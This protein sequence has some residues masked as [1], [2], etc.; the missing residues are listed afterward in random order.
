LK[1]KGIITILGILFFVIAGSGFGYGINVE[2]MNRQYFNSAYGFD[3]ATGTH[4]IPSTARF[5]TGSIGNAGVEKMNQEYFESRYGFEIDPN[6]FSTFGAGTDWSHFGASII[7]A[8]S[9]NTISMQKT[10]TPLAGIAL[11]ILIVTAGLILP[12]RKQ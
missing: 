12:K 10:A 4:S 3:I 1:K 9:A 11:A 6:A 7:T 5:S 2:D 8:Q